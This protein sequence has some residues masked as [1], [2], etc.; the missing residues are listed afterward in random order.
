MILALGVAAVWA[1]RSQSGP[2]RPAPLA[3]A[4]ALLAEGKAAEAEKALAR[5]IAAEPSDPDPWLLRLEVLR[6]EDRPLEAQA[7]GWK[8][9]EAV[10]ERA[11][12]NILKAMTLALLAE[13]PDSIARSALARWS[14][15]DPN[16]L[17]ARV[18]LLR[19]IAAAPHPGD[20]DRP[21][22][23]AELDAIVHA[24]PTD[25]PARE[26]LALALIDAGQPDRG[27][28]VLE[29]WPDAVRD[30]RFDRLRGRWDLEFDHKPELAAEELGRALQSL[31]QDWRTRS[32][33]ARAL[34]AAGRD[35]EAR[36]AA[37]SAERLREALDPIPLGRRLDEA[38]AR[39]D[40][41]A[42]RLDLA[43]LCARVGLDRLARAWERDARPKGPAQGRGSTSFLRAEPGP[44]G[45]SHPRPGIGPGRRLRPRNLYARIGLLARTQFTC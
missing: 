34:K 12:R 22:R 11:R 19:R 43:D 3:E 23:I 42:A 36:Q 44:G 18:A 4:R 24:R 40:E 15:S 33:L 28:T 31:P 38:L 29:T 32:R 39:L 7:E 20:P 2:S 25:A 30:A 10:P 21:A 1:V 9:Y 26:A 5:A 41:P 37:D 14:R 16:D 6:V 8:A 45:P 35:A 27:R 17:D 13:P